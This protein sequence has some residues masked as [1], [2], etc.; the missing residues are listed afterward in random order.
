MRGGN[1]RLQ[2]TLS[3]VINIQTAS[4][5]NS[6]GLVVCDTA[7][8]GSEQTY[9]HRPRLV[10]RQQCVVTSLMFRRAGAD[11]EHASRLVY[12]E[13]SSAESPVFLCGHAQYFSSS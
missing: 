4:S 1:Q 6:L 12:N 5:A 3:P 10:Y 7:L 2:A 8:C 11:G 9:K 13:S